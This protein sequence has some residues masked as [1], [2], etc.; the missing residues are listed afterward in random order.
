[1]DLG[2]F[3]IGEIVAAAADKLLDRVLPLLDERGDDLARF[4]IVERMSALDFPVHQ[5]RFEHSERAQAHR[6]AGAHRIG[7]G[8]TDIRNKRHSGTGELANREQT[9]QKP[10]N[11]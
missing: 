3:L 8:S 10:R 6:I 5:R 2:R 9:N 11:P 1:M 4:V 7:D